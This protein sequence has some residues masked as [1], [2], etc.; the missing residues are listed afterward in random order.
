[1]RHL[2]NIICSRRSFQDLGICRSRTGFSFYPDSYQANLPLLIAI[3]CL[4]AVPF[5]FP[6]S[7]RTVKTAR[8]QKS[9]RS[10]HASRGNKKRAE[11][12]HWGRSYLGFT[13]HQQNLHHPFHFFWSLFFF[14]SSYFIS[15]LPIWHAFF[16]NSFEIQKKKRHLSLSSLLSGSHRYEAVYTER[17]G[18]LPPG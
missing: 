10:K 16:F 12:K 14:P 1:M 9:R 4:R 5:I 15:A 3:P 8:Q 11:W 18:N 7:H 6:S 2:D 17:L 13:A